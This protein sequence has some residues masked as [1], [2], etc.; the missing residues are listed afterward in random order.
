LTEN[1][2][3]LFRELYGVAFFNCSR[4]PHAFSSTMRVNIN[5]MH[6]SDENR[7]K[8]IPKLSIFEATGSCGIDGILSNCTT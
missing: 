3:T 8:N 1:R 6:V 7:M 5:A 2:A 4:N